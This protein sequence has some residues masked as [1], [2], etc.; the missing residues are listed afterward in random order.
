MLRMKKVVSC[1]VFFIFFVTNLMPLNAFAEENQSLTSLAQEEMPIIPEG[2]ESSNDFVL[3]DLLNGTSDEPPS[4]IVPDD[5]S[6]ETSDEAPSD[7]ESDDVNTEISDESPSDIIPDDIDTDTSLLSIMEAGDSPT[8]Y[9]G[10]GTSSGMMSDLTSLYRP[11]GVQGFNADIIAEGDIWQRD[12]SGGDSNQAAFTTTMPLEPDG[13]PVQ[14]VLVADTFRSRWISSEELFSGTEP[15]EPTRML[16]QDGKIIYQLDGGGSTNTYFQLQPYDNSNAIVIKEGVSTYAEVDF[17]SP[18]CYKS[19]RFLTTGIPVQMETF[20]IV[21][22]DNSFVT[23]QGGFNFGGAASYYESGNKDGKSVP[24]VLASRIALE[25]AEMEITKKTFNDKNAATTCDSDSRLDPELDSLYY[26]TLSAKVLDLTNITYTDQDGSSTTGDLSSKLISKLVFD[27]ADFTAGDFVDYRAGYMLAVSGLPTAT[28]AKVTWKPETPTSVTYFDLNWNDVEGETKYVLE[29]AKDSDFTDFVEGFNGKELAADS[30]TAK[31]TG[32]LPQTDYYCRITGYRDEFAG[33]TSDVKQVTTADASGKFQITYDLN[34]VPGTAPTDDGYYENGAST[35]V[36]DG[37]SGC[38]IRTS[39]QAPVVFQCW[40]TLSDGNGEDYNPPQTYI[41]E[42]SSAT[43]YAKWMITGQPEGSGTADDPYLMESSANLIWLSLQTRSRQNHYENEYFKQ[44]NDIDM[45]GVNWFPIR[46]FG[47]NYDGNGFRI[48]NLTM[49][50]TRAQADAAGL[51]VTS[52]VPFPMVSG[53]YYNMDDSTSSDGIPVYFER[54][55]FGLFESTISYY[56]KGQSDVIPEL[57]DIHLVG[58]KINVDFNTADPDFVLKLESAEDAGGS[59]YS[60]F[61]APFVGA[62]GIVGVTGCGNSG[63]LQEPLLGDYYSNLAIRN[64][65]VDSTSIII[66]NAPNAAVGGL[67]GYAFSHHGFSYSDNRDN[68]FVFDCNSNEGSI[69]VESKSNAV[70][71]SA[72]GET[73]DLDW[74]ADNDLPYKN[75]FEP[76]LSVGGL[77]GYLGTNTMPGDLGDGR[78]DCVVNSYNRGDITVHSGNTISNNAVGYYT[79]DT[80]YTDPGISDELVRK[81]YN[82]TITK[83]QKRI[84]EKTTGKSFSGVTRVGGLLGY[85]HIS[86]NTYL[87]SYKNGDAQSQSA[88]PALNEIRSDFCNLYNTGTVTVDKNV[89]GHNGNSP[90]DLMM[91]GSFIGQVRRDEFTH[92]PDYSWDSGA[93]YVNLM[94]SFFTEGSTTL[95]GNEQDAPIGYTFAPPDASIIDEN[96]GSGWVKHY[97][98][99][100]EANFDNYINCKPPIYFVDYDQNDSGFAGTYEYD[101]H[102]YD[103]HPLSWFSDLT[104]NALDTVWPAD[105]WIIEDGSL[106]EIRLSMFNLAGIRLDSYDKETAGCTPIT[107]GDDGVKTVMLRPGETMNLVTAGILYD[108]SGETLEGIGAVSW[109]SSN[110]SVA[111]LVTENVTPNGLDTSITSALIT[112]NTA[113]ETTISALTATG[114]LQDTVVVVVEGIPATGIEITYLDKSNQPQH[115]L[116][117][118]LDIGDYTMPNQLTAVVLPESATDKNITWSSSNP[119]IASV[120][121]EGIIHVVGFGQVYIYAKT[122]GDQFTGRIVLKVI[123][124][125]AENLEIDK[126]DIQLNITYNSNPTEKITATASRNDGKDVSVKRFRWTSSDESV[127]TVSGTGLVYAAGIGTAIIKASTVDGSN[128]ESEPCTVTV[129]GKHVTGI[130]MLN[131]ADKTREMELKEKARFSVVV[132]PEDVLC[133]DIIWTSSDT[134]KLKVTSNGWVTPLTTFNSGDVSVTAVTVDGG[135]S[136]EF[137]PKASIGERRVEVYN[138]KDF[139]KLTSFDSKQI[140]YSVFPLDSE[141]RDVEFT[142]SNTGVATVSE[143]GNVSTLSAGTAVITLTTRHNRVR[144]SIV[145]KA[146]DMA[147]A[148]I[149]VMDKKTLNPVADVSIGILDQT[150]STGGN[151]IAYVTY[152]LGDDGRFIE[153][154]KS[155]Y[156]TKV[157]TLSELAPGSYTLL[158]EADDG[159]PYFKYIGKE[160]SEGQYGNMTEGCVT[161]S[162]DEISTVSAWIDWKD[163][164]PG[165]VFLSKGSKQFRFVPFPTGLY[166]IRS[167]KFY[168]EVKEEPGNFYADAYADPASLPAPPAGTKAKPQQAAISKIIFWNFVDF[169]RMYGNVNL[170]NADEGKSDFSNSGQNGMF[171]TDFDMDLPKGCPVQIEIEEDDFTLSVAYK[172]GLENG[173]G[174]DG[175][176][177]SEDEPGGDV[178]EMSNEELVDSIKEA[179]VSGKMSD[180]LKELTEPPAGNKLEKRMEVSVE[181]YGYLK[182]KLIQ[183]PVFYDLNDVNPYDLGIDMNTYKALKAMNMPSMPLTLVRLK[184]N[185]GGLKVIGDGKVTYSQ[186]F[187]PGGVPVYVELVIGASIEQIVKFQVLDSGYTVFKGSTELKP[188]AGCYGAVGIGSVLSIGPTLN[189]E[190]PMKITYPDPVGFSVKL[191]MQFGLRVKVILWTKNFKFYNREWTLYSINQEEEREG[192]SLNTVNAFN[193]AETDPKLESFELLP[194]DY[195]TAGYDTDTCEFTDLTRG[196]SVSD[197]KMTSGYPEIMPQ[198]LDL[199]NG[200]QMLLWEDDDTKRPLTDRTALQYTITTDYGETW[201]EPVVIDDD[202]TA[203]G[204]F[205]AAADQNGNVYVAFQSVAFPLDPMATLQDFT[206]LMQIKTA[207]YDGTAFNAPQV[208]SNMIEPAPIE[209]SDYVYEANILPQIVVNGDSVAV[210]WLVNTENNILGTTGNNVI[211]YSY[212]DGNSFTEPIELINTENF[213]YDLTA[214]LNGGSLTIAYL[215][216]DDGDMATMTDRS[217]YMLSA[218]SETGNSAKVTTGDLTASPTLARVN[219][220][221]ALYWY[222]DKNIKYLPDIGMPDDVREV[223]SKVNEY[224]SP[225]TP[226][227]KIITRED[228]SVLLFTEGGAVEQTEPDSYS[229]TKPIKNVNAAIYDPEMQAWGGFSTNLTQHRE[230]I[231]SYGADLDATGTIHLAVSEL[232]HLNEDTDAA[233]LKVFHL[234]PSV[235]LAIEDQSIYYNNYDVFEGAASLPIAVY[236]ENNGQVQSTGINIELY[237][238]SDQLLNSTD[239]PDA[240]IVPGEESKRFVIEC[241]LDAEITEKAVRLIV[242]PYG[243]VQDIEL[244]DNE[245]STV[246]GCGDLELGKIRTAASGDITIADFN[247]LNNSYKRLDNIEALLYEADEDGQAVGE[248]VQTVNIGSLDAYCSTGAFA[249][250]DAGTIDFN[251]DTSKDYII[252]LSTDSTQ[253][254][255]TV[256][257]S[258]YITV[259][260]PDR[261]VIPFDISVK[262]A[263][264]EADSLTFSINAANLTDRNNT[265]TIELSVYNG[266][267]DSETPPE[268]LMKTTAALSIAANSSTEELVTIDDAEGVLVDA[269]LV[270]ARFTSASSGGITDTKTGSTCYSN[271]AAD[272][273]D[274]LI[275]DS[276]NRLSALAVT[277]GSISPAFSADN[278]N[279]FITVNSNSITLAATAEDEISALIS[280][281]V[282]NGQKLYL[283]SEV[284]SDAIALSPG[285]VLSITVEAENGSLRTYLLTVP[286]KNTGSGGGGGGVLVPPVTTTA[287]ADIIINGKAESGG[288]A[289][290]TTNTSGQ[291][292]TTITVD[293]QKLLQRLDQEGNNSV[294]TIQTDNGSDV[295]IGELNGQ[296]IKSMENKKAVLEI[297]TENATYSLPAQQINIDVIS[298]QLGSGIELKDIKIQVEIAEASSQEVELAESLARK[299]N[300]T[301][302]VPPIKFSIRC[303]YGDKTIEINSFS[304]YVERAIAIPDGV[305]PDK[306]TTAIAVDPDGT[307]RHVPTRITI[308]D[309]KYFVVINSRTNSIYSV[310]WHPVAFNDA[311]NH[312]A[313]EAINNMGSRMVVSGVRNEMFDPDRDITRAEFA[314]IIVRGLGLKP[315]TGKAQFTDVKNTDWFSGYIITAAEQKIISGYGNGKFGPMDKITREQAMTMISMAM[316][317]T[318]LKAD[319]ATGEAEKLLAGFSD[320]NQSEAYAKSNIA[321]CIKTDIISGRDGNLIAP[322]DNIT[323]AEVTIIVRNLLQKSNLI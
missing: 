130:K 248:P 89:S 176:S 194:R 21:F 173:G 257:N 222:Q 86:A 140:Y 119:E 296:I 189:G 180:K 201:S 154:K 224:S 159:K 245:A 187:F 145:V 115:D 249:E 40:N 114:G 108:G 267:P 20:K 236:V 50:Y 297:K 32:L 142:S 287:N 200:K 256:N 307:V 11:V 288:T 37:P 113:G 61:L 69:T 67:V 182:G 139:L 192:S 131:E 279:Y 203:D 204:T 44:T 88:L 94:N 209:I 178:D 28:P 233:R 138:R 146:T 17:E 104:E 103:V 181:I 157:I 214:M 171:N 290:T 314:A 54:Y 179:I 227:F 237:D 228:R 133:R 251:G 129:T 202:G 80:S 220:K 253:E 168:D 310:I 312:W 305:D 283:T 321:V 71:I 210:V 213:I 42:S 284:E 216:D 95:N 313:K 116:I 280:Y 41:F 198:L 62:G 35:T 232:L 68:L 12:P 207:K 247:I 274:D 14:S 239:Y 107:P 206:G 8:T 219:G 23:V 281:T 25:N 27:D 258:G 70:K 105:R 73:R 46:A 118:D 124:R 266:E 174:D 217:I 162:R 49:E 9:Y 282:N 269:Y 38:F 45:S 165:S 229:T 151:G 190:L 10:T 125:L 53:D 205:S 161:S 72:N 234:M 135:F 316:K 285:D 76:S 109:E 39:D 261:P 22:A 170:E 122:T 117:S 277:G 303:T 240:I 319:L 175:W 301:I 242:K 221:T 127:A 199:G 59:S 311:A 74:S 244:S 83:G 63:G 293:S 208:V 215:S 243:G 298:E 132:E 43:L 2:D 276:N 167:T 155:G 262:G 304:S 57:S 260:N 225:A 164:V 102:S 16:P 51:S 33:T 191:G 1:V 92:N 4:D 6:N 34:G 101:N 309:G 66:V 292:V 241:P 55:A 75:V 143:T 112:A 188:Y 24:F 270:V 134:S 320:A 254:I 299:G 65:T 295:V 98:Y 177:Q 268:L 150:F 56:L 308:I 273:V 121:S 5:L 148:S 106:P 147:S 250:M 160:S 183:E 97:Y 323:R 226:D 18:A 265:G 186:Q 271:V 231:G 79:D 275:P 13:F 184:I 78:G 30:T 195:L 126:T 144:E 196:R 211:R 110:T 99:K 153:L 252:M 322:K 26:H 149:K 289:V 272:I 255:K 263:Y 7:I 48:I 264:K 141:Y 85:L 77:I 294:I 137:T 212:K 169:N 87:P 230:D 218:S 52:G 47:G 136:V 19:L 286:V 306:I 84:D 158:M 96:T 172:A 111:S 223:F 185:E 317:L 302:V 81:T 123:P 163:T 152:P 166:K 246:I 60:Y 15:G 235:D 100:G 278:L 120:S 193:L 259:M 90:D 318:G 238:S 91:A 197:V 315:G 128:L 36:M 29:V 156:R 3:E 291:T 82:S 31:V 64:C 93:A 300:F 58:M